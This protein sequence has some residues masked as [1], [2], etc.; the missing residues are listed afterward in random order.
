MAAATAL[1]GKELRE[2]TGAGNMDCKKALAATDGDMM[3]QLTPFVRRICGQKKAGRT[4]EGIVDVC[5]SGDA[6]K[7]VVI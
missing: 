1:N 3:W 2:M 6:K 4:A 7:A 5:V